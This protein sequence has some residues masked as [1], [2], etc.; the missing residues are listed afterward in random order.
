M[1]APR[2]QHSIEP[3]VDAANLALN[4]FDLASEPVFSLDQ[5]AIG[6]ELERGRLAARPRA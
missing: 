3:L 1:L 6:N 4:I 5:V 2:Q